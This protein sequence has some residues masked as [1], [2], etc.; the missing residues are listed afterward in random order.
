MTPALSVRQT[1]ILKGLIDEYI[2]SAEPVGSEA[3]DKKYGLGVS[4]A[5]IRHE[6]SELT[7]LG[8]LKQPHTSAGRVPTSDAMKFYI[9][10][11]MVEKSVSVADEVKVKEDVWDSRNN[12]EELMKETVHALANRTQCLAIGTLD[13]GDIWHAGYA[14]V[15]LSPILHDFGVNPHIFSMIEEARRMHELF[16]ERMTGLSPVEVIFGEEL[17]WAGLDYL[18]VVGTRFKI[19]DHEAALGIVG[20]T[21]LR[22]HTVIPYL[23]VFREMITDVTK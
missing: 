6:M 2:E 8:Y 10:Q 18:G 17:G 13:D 12:L 4:P 3:L 14:N 23:R 15:F 16:F 9:D 19:R 5:T 1:Q 7:R 22:Y 21:N 20:P 11:L